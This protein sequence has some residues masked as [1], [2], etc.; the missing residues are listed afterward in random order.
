VS[1]GPPAGA[2]EANTDDIARRVETYLRDR[3][4]I[5]AAVAPERGTRD[6]AK[7]T[8]SVH[9]SA[10]AESERPTASDHGRKPAVDPRSFVEGGSREAGRRPSPAPVDFVAEADVKRAIERGDRIRIGPQTIITPL[11]RDLGE[12][13]G[14]FKRR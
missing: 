3:G 2:P 5:P 14:I 8:A 11:A 10:D 9:G 1:P 4:I 7:D 6:A 13:H 12:Q